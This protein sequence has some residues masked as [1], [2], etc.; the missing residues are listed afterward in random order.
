M[1]LLGDGTA[2]MGGGLSRDANGPIMSVSGPPR[3]LSGRGSAGKSSGLQTAGSLSLFS[4]T[5][6]MALTMSSMS[7]SSP[8]RIPDDQ[9]AT[10]FW[11]T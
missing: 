11:H 1:P 3:L 9:K 5:L 8:R 7:S 4:W 6:K 10:T 2:I